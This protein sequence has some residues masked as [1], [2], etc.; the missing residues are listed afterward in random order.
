M[1][2]LIVF[3]L[4]IPILLNAQKIGSLAEAKPNIDFPN[5]AVGIDLMIGEGGFGFG[6]FYRYNFSKTFTGFIDFSISS[7]SSGP[8]KLRVINSGKSNSITDV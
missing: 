7:S 2:K 5:N 8:A 6:S 3:I 4:L 1:K